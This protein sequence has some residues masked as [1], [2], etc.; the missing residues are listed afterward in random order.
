[1]LSGITHTGLIFTERHVIL[2]FQKLLESSDVVQQNVTWSSEVEETFAVSRAFISKVRQSSNAASKVSVAFQLLM[3]YLSLSMLDEPTQAR[4]AL[5]DVQ[6]S[7]VKSTAAQHA[8]T[9]EQEEEEE[10]QPKKKRR[11]KNSCCE[12]EEADK[13]GQVKKKIKRNCCVEEEE[14]EEEEEEEHEWIDVL[15]ELLLSF[16]AK[17]DALLRMIVTT[18]FRLVIDY[19]TPTAMSMLIEVGSYEM[20]YSEASLSPL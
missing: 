3:L 14:K 4:D 12:E 9:E 17:D 16:L 11:K 8:T 10:E 7:Y 2:I 13:A 20:I 15:M 18:T 19:L 6:V 5:L 1:M